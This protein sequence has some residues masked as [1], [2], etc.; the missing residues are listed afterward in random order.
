M[1]DS[2]FLSARSIA[3][4]VDVPERTVR[5][6]IASGA[7]PSTRLGR[8]VRVSRSDLETFLSAR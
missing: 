2:S 5:R 8:L 7:L 1:T 3:V 6:W 4:K